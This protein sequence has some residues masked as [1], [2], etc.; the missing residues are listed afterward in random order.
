[1]PEANHEWTQIRLQDFNSIDDYNHTIHKVC[2]KLQFCEKEPS[3]EDKIENTLQIML[4]SD[5]SYNTNIKPKTTNTMLTSFVTYSRL[6]SMINLLLRIITNIMLGL[7]VSLRFITMRRKQVLLRIQIQRKM[8]G[9]LGAGA[10]GK[11]T[12]SS[13]RR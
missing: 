8:V 11:R 3:E 10:I 9:L 13:P 4:P 12:K 7:L 5:R 6:R 1:L 2:A